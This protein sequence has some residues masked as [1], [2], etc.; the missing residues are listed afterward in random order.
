M[1]QTS[2]E[3][4]EVTARIAGMVVLDRRWDLMILEIFS[5]L[6]DSMSL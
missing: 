2:T 1:K 6:N 3:L 4:T 5:N